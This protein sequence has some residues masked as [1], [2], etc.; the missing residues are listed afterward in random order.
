M[1]YADKLKAILDAKKAKHEAE[2]LTRDEKE[3][4]DIAALISEE[5]TGFLR[6]H[7]APDLPGHVVFRT[8]SRREF[9]AFHH[10]Q[11]VNP[12]ERGAQDRKS[13]A[14]PNLGNSCVI[15]PDVKT[16]EG[17]ASLDKLYEAIPGL[18]DQIAAAVIALAQG[19]VEEEGKD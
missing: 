4:D 12:N 16:P 6:T 15:H 19:R 8:P 18:E 9:A 1:A 13:K 3:L 11:F 2:R 7:A 10:A 14:G 17:K 5:G